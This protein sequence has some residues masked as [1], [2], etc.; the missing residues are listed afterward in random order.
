MPEAV[1][2]LQAVSSKELRDLQSNFRAQT[3]TDLLRFDRLDERINDLVAVVNEVKR[4]LMTML[5]EQRREHARIAWA[6]WAIAAALCGF[7]AKGIL[8]GLAQ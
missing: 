4:E 7:L 1:A 8:P 2:R 6:G 5:N 3:A